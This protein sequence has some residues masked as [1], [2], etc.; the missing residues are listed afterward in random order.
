MTENKKVTAIRERTGSQSHGK[1]G[2]EG[3]TLSPPGF[4]EAAVVRRKGFEDRTAPDAGFRVGFVEYGCSDVLHGWRAR[5]YRAR[6]SF[7]FNCALGEGNYVQTGWRSAM[8][9]GL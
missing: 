4:R 6:S 9:F 1:R 7:D 3:G 8:I 5:E 2:G